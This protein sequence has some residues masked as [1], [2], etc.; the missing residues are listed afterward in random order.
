MN[1]VAG[2]L[3]EMHKAIQPVKHPPIDC[4]HICPSIKVYPWHAADAAARGAYY[5]T[6]EEE[7]DFITQI[8]TIGSDGAV[9]AVKQ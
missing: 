8:G 5:K 6:E 3:L 9:F 7:G 2:F 1:V 4:A